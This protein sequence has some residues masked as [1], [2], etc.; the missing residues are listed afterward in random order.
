MN[1]QLKRTL[2]YMR[3]LIVAPNKNRRKMLQSYPAF[4]VSD[5]V[6]ILY[7]ILA[8]NVS[9]RNPNYIK[10]MKSNKGVMTK[11]FNVARKPSQRKKIILS[12]K[13]GFIGAMV[14]II[15]SVLGGLAGSAL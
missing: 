15:A 13:G 2:P 6:E 5:M 1:H 4:V 10:A 9:L 8:K 7:N 12:Q 14:P 11:L 3:L